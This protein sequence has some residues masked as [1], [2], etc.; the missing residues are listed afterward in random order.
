[1]FNKNISCFV[2]FISKI[3]PKTVKIVLEH[4]GWVTIIQSDLA[5]FE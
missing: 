1:M 3:K 5:E 2:F 4:P